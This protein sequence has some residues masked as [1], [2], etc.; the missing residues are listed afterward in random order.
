MC[1]GVMELLS[2]TLGPATGVDATITRCPRTAVGGPTSRNN[3][4]ETKAPIEW[5]RPI[6]T[7]RLV[8]VKRKLDQADMFRLNQNIRP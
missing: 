6:A 2:N 7:T 1:H 3:R 5:K 4:K 8:E